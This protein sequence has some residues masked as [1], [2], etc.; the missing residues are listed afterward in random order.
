MRLLNLANGYY[1]VIKKKHDDETTKL[2]MIIFGL[3]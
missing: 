1:F 2:S 3:E